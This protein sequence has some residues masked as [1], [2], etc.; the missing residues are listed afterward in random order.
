MV[1]LDQKT[2]AELWRVNE[3]SRQCGCNITGAVAGQRHRV[4]AVSPAA[5][6]RTAAI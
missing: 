6:P 5:T 4:E 1:A 2:G 3:D